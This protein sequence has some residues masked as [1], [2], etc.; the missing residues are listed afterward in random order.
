MK[1]TLI[2]A[3]C[4]LNIDFSKEQIEKFEIYASL[5]T[6]WNEKINLTAIT[7]PREIAVK[8]F[9]DCASCL[10][11]TALSGSVIDVGT[12]AGFP[13]MVLKIL[14][15]EIELTLL[16]SLNKRILFLEDVT[17]K[18]SLTGI[19]TVHMR[20]EDGGRDKKLRENFDFSVSRAVANLSTLSEYCLP[21]VK[22]GGEFISMKGPDISEELCA[23]QNAI[24]ILGGEVSGI[25]NMSLLNGEINHTVISIKKVRQTPS[26]YPRK[27][28]KPSK[29]PLK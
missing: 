17:E 1:E 16:D 28:G 7:D 8:H 2:K 24:K 27:A 5:L 3:L 26:V 25:K 29:E 9:A 11:Y 18:L 12:G 4:D 13:G 21:F 20:A 23:A 15:P 14:R 22:T 6:E 19:K 10:K